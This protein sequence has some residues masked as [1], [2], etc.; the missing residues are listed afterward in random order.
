MIKCDAKCRWLLLQS[1]VVV[2][3]TLWCTKKWY[4]KY[5]PGV[6]FNT[7]RYIILYSRAVSLSLRYCTQ[8][9]NQNYAVDWFFRAYFCWAVE[10]SGSCLSWQYS[11]LSTT[12]ASLLTDGCMSWHVLLLSVLTSASINLLLFKKF[13]LLL[14]FSV[15]IPYQLH[16]AFVN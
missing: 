13:D 12:A 6:C 16:G 14:N 5:T 1:S 4:L 8:I 9:E 2:I 7:S 11:L 10:R 15:F 3:F